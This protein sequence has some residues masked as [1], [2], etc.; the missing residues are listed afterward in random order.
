MFVPY[1]WCFMWRGLWDNFAPNFRSVSCDWMRVGFVEV[2]RVYV[3]VSVWSSA[4]LL[5]WQLLLRSLQKCPE[6]SRIWTD[7]LPDQQ[8]QNVLGWYVKLI[9]SWLFQ[10][11]VGCVERANPQH[12]GPSKQTKR[13]GFMMKV[14]VA[15][16]CLFA[17]QVAWV[18]SQESL[19]GSEAMRKPHTDVQDR[20]ASLPP[21]SADISQPVSDWSARIPENIR[22]ASQGELMA[23]AGLILG[24]LYSGYSW[25]RR[26]GKKCVKVKEEGICHVGEAKLW[27]GEKCFWVWHRNFY[28]IVTLLQIHIRG[29]LCESEKNTGFVMKRNVEGVDVQLSDSQLKYIDRKNMWRLVVFTP[30]FRVP[31]GTHKLPEW[32]ESIVKHMQGSPDLAFMES[33]SVELPR[34]DTKWLAWHESQVWGSSKT[35]DC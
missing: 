35:C 5:A 34:L 18:S 19:D 22:N 28:C 9:Q 33:H 7:R 13:A 20:I 25:I 23:G 10:S 4:M 27:E 11:A 12:T 31:E 2:A 17:W 6:P 1:L 21:L 8:S 15:G 30:S 26:C 29:N 3:S 16:A 32:E 14:R 24:A